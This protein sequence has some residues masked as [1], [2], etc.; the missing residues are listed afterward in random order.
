MGLLTWILLGVIVLVAIGLGV[1]V[2]FTGLFRGAEII[3]ENP[4][5]QNASQ[6][7]RDFIEDKI[8]DALI[9]V[10]TDDSAYQKGDAVLITVKNNGDETKSF[11]DAALGLQVRNVDTDRDYPVM[12]AQVITELGPGESK[13]ITWKEGSAPAGN[14]EA[15]VAT[16]AGESAKTSFEITE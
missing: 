13:T 8:N 5:V 10:T 16:S 3:G 6:Q 7:A 15:T 1:G 9:V 4:A 14:Y 12:S 11:P 2:F